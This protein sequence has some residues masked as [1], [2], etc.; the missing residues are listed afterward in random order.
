MTMRMIVSRTGSFLQRLPM[1]RAWL[2]AWLFLAAAFSA[3]QV[4]AAPSSPV[5]AGR[6]GWLFLESELHFSQFPAFWGESA[7]KASRSSKPE[8][9][10]PAPAII[11]FHKQLEARGIVL[12]LAP[13]PP[14]SWVSPHA[15]AGPFAGKDADSLGRFYEV[16]R[17]GGVRVVD[18][19]PEFEKREG[20][21]EGMYCKTDSHWSGAG[22]V[23]AAQA[24]AGAVAPLLKQPAANPLQTTWKSVRAPGD[25]ASLL[26]PPSTEEEEMKVRQVSDTGGDALKA[27]PASPLLLIGDSHTLVFH[28]FLSD[29]AGLPDQLAHETGVVPDWI[30]TRGSGANAVRISLLRRAAKD[31]KYLAS[32]KVVVWCF[33]AREFTEADQGWQQVPLPAPPSQK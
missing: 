29:K 19:R 5:V 12:V 31:P 2:R 9:A 30:G 6:D 21:G 16:L 33:A 11:D 15:P 18:L 3:V 7:H 14:K 4:S 24:L 25:L 10:D 13:V 8:T 20:S 26:Q 1:L 22:C 32:K 23:A 27:D 28:D 17:Q